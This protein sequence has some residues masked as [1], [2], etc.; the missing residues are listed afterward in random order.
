MTTIH[1]A[2]KRHRKYDL[3]IWNYPSLFCIIVKSI[4]YFHQHGNQHPHKASIT[5][6]LCILPWNHGPESQLDRLFGTVQSYTWD[7]MMEYSTALDFQ[8]LYFYRTIEYNSLC[9]IY[10]IQKESMMH[11]VDCVAAK[12]VKTWFFKNKFIH[13]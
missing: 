11:M 10:T 12:Q 2:F 9:W 8:R 1:T 6:I 4:S 5:W 7:H 13:W 3:L